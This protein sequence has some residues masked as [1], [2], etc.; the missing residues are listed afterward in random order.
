MDITMPIMDGLAA[1]QSIR[2]H[3]ETRAI[4]VV[5]LRPQMSDAVWRE[6]ALRAGCDY[7][8]AKPV[9]F[10]SCDRL[11]AVTYKPC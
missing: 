7:C 8:C 4:P 3:A 1:T 10:E 9:D 6:R 2:E 11:L 5:A